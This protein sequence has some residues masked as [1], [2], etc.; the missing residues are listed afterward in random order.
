MVV[1]LLPMVRVVS[2]A[3]SAKANSLMDVTGFAR[4]GV[5]NDQFCRTVVDP[6]IHPVTVMSAPLSVYVRPVE[7]SAAALACEACRTPSSPTSKH[8]AVAG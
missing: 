8:A 1:T 2:E 6:P 7:R 4:N 5:G 3:P